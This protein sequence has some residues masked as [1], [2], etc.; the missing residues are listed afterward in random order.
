MVLHDALVAEKNLIITRNFGM[1]LSQNKSSWLGAPKTLGSVIANDPNKTNID[2]W[3]VDDWGFD[4]MHDDM[5]H[6][7]HR[8][9]RCLRC[10]VCGVI[11][12]VCGVRCAVCG[13][14]CAVCCVLC[15]VCCVPGIVR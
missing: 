8:C 4:G 1:K 12:D 7:D 5:P 13:V 15:A 2:I 3:I 9:A 6:C 10:A 14:R 11:C